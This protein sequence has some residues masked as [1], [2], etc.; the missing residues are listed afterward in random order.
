MPL[1]IPRFRSTRT[2][3]GNN[4][5]VYLHLR[6]RNHRE[7]RS[8]SRR[9]GK[10]CAYLSPLR[11]LPAIMTLLTIQSGAPPKPSF[12]L[13]G[14]ALYPRTT[15]SSASHG[16]FQRASAPLSSPAKNTPNVLNQ[17]SQLDHFPDRP[18][19]RFAFLGLSVMTESSSYYR[20]DVTFHVKHLPL[21]VRWMVASQAGA[22]CSW[23]R[24][25]I[26]VGSRPATRH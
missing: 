20:H 2:E 24:V 10:S 6:E 19:S 1:P 11:F 17:A 23:K 13:S 18:F 5:N 8:T 3:T 25:S 4:R 16:R 14:K 12:G 7:S 22:P 15:N 26:R 9:Q 21:Y